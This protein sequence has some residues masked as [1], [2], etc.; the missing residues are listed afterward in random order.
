MGNYKPMTTKVEKSVVVNVPVSTAYNQWTQFEEFPRFMGGVEQV[1]QLSKD[2]LEWVAEIAGVRRQ[3]IARIMIQEPD[4][5][6][7][8]AALEGATNAGAVTF[9]E[10]GPDQT[11]VNLTLEYEPTGLLEHLGELFH[12]VE[13]QA[14]DDLDNFKVFI[15]AEGEATGAWRGSVNAGAPI[16]TPGLED[17]AASRRDSGK[18]HAR[19]GEVTP[20]GAAPSA[21]DL[22]LGVGLTGSRASVD[23]DVELDPE[24]R[25]R[26]DTLGGP[27]ISR[28]L[29]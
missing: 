19:K 9:E 14:E 12:L 21:N 13:K 7:A 23:P 20:S 10:A 25:R 29:I 27:G 22:D 28:P 26:D 3:W 16:G 11:T 1:R 15:E 8:W 17:A 18:V 6:V 2:R 5:K 24:S 4:S